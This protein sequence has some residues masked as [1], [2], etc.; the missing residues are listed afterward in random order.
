[1]R[2]LKIIL[3]IG[4]IITNTALYGADAFQWQIGE[5]LVYRVRWSF[6]RLG[7]LEMHLTDTVRIAGQLLYKIDLKMDSNPVLIF[8]NL[9]NRYRCLVDSLYRPVEYVVKEK[10][11][12][13][14]NRMIY[15]FNYD[16]NTVTWQIYDP[17]DSTK[18]IKQK[19]MELKHYM[20]DGISLT[21]FARAHARE[22]VS[23][24][25]YSFIYDRVGPVD[26]YFRQEPESIYFKPLKRYFQTYVVQGMFH[27]KGIAGVTGNYKGWFTHDARR[28][29]LG[30]EMKVFVGNVKVELERWEK[31]NP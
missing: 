15:R 31:W 10:N 4:T 7:T 6:I 27:L 12:K 26:I 19:K 20:Y 24:R 17:L 1:M 16:S 5:K 13:Q 25:V 3:I 22:N 29:P 21:Y 30:A 9:H 8:V 23:F 14:I 18:V 2:W 28:I 11:G